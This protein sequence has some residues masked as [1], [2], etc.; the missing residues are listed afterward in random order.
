[1]ESHA[2]GAATAA[3]FVDEWRALEGQ[4]DLGAYAPPPPGP[5]APPSH[6]TEHRGEYC[7]TA[8]GGASRVV[9]KKGVAHSDC[10]SACAADAQCSCYD[11]APKGGHCRQYHGAPGLAASSSGYDAYTRNDRSSLAD[12]FDEV[13]ARLEI[14]A[15]DAAAFAKAI[16]KY[17]HD[18]TK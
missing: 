2:A 12:T 14:G 7:S 4:V 10:E 17:F 16:E 9:D 15:A 18:I 1:M 8:G 13:T 3:S 11:F 6:F 5:P